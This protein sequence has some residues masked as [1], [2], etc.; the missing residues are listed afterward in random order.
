M[1]KSLYRTLSYV[2]SHPVN[3]N[4]KMRAIKDFIGWQLASRL[5]PGGVLF[6]W[7]NDSVLAIEIE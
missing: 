2:A 4:H 3:Q 5:V 1:V 6:R 7:I